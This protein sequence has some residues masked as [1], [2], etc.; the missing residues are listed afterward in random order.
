MQE[1]KQP[2]VEAPSWVRAKNPAR[3]LSALNK[4]YFSVCCHNDVIAEIPS[5]T[6]VLS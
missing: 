6:M 5:N 3:P 2:Q 4:K 1:D